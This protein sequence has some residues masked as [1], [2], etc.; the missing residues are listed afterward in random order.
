[1]AEGGTKDRLAQAVALETKAR[2]EHARGEFS[3]AKRDYL[4]AC[5]VFQFCMQYEA[6]PKIK[7]MVRDRLT[8]LV[9]I[10]EKL[11]EQLEQP[12]TA[13]YTPSQGASAPATAQRPPSGKGP[14]A[15]PGEEAKDETDLE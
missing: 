5:K 3:E 1:M 15:A 12:Q 11:N 8:E 2:E 14:P 10:T 6:N 7:D 13:G 4:N 9:T